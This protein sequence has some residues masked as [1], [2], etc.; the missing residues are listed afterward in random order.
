STGVW[1]QVDKGGPFT[2]T[3]T[4]KN[5][6]NT[7]SFPVLPNVICDNIKLIAKVD[8]HIFEKTNPLDPVEIG[9]INPG[10]RIVGGGVKTKKVLIW[11]KSANVKDATTYVLDPGGAPAGGIKVGTVGPD[12][13]RTVIHGGIYLKGG[14]KTESAPGQDTGNVRLVRFAGPAF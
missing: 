11:T 4:N 12:R 13:M 5:L 10:V 6:S 1:V 9:Q 2:A 14:M 3:N 8:W 7:A